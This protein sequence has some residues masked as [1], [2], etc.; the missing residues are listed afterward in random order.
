[1]LGEVSQTKEKKHKLFEKNPQKKHFHKWYW[2]E[3]KQKRI[4]SNNGLVL[5]QTSLSAFFVNGELMNLNLF[6]FCLSYLWIET[7]QQNRE[8]L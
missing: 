6:L 7:L 4:T 1:M 8:I 3:F 2:K 5:T